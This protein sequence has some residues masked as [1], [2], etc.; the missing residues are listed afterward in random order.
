MMIE[1]FPDLETLSSAA[2][3]LFAEKAQESAQA[4]GRFDVALAG[5]STPNRAYELLAGPPYRDWIPWTMVHVF[6][7]D[8]RC[9]PHE[10]PRSN[11]YHARRALLDHVPIPPRQIHPIP[12]LLEP[13]FA[14]LQYETLLRTVFAG[15]PP[16]FG[17]VFLGLGANGHT[18][19]LFPDTQVLKERQHWATEVYIAEQNLYR[20]T[21]T[22]PLLNEAAVVA[23]LVSGVDKAAVLRDVL[24]GPRDPFHLPA[25]LI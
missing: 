6:W 25:Q 22:A 4:R 5:G 18:A 12:Y 2:A 3:R 11:Y 10:D 13:H 7:G 19:S 24:E 23:F 20:I 9:V 16:R 15:R 17:L 8:E 14:A 1:I 21:M